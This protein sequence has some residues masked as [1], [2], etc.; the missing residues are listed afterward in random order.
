VWVAGISLAMLSACASH[1]P[2]I[3][4]APRLAGYEHTIEVPDADLLTV[5]PQMQ[6]FLDRYVLPYENLDTR[7]QL[8]TLAVTHSGVIGFTRD[9]D[10][11]LTASEAFRQRT[12][13][14]LS[15]ANM[16]V[17]LARASGLEANYQ[18][19]IVQPQWSS[20][21][22]T[23]LLAKHIN[24]AVSSRHYRYVIDVT[25]ERVPTNST[26][27]LLSDRQAASLYYN[28]LGVEA[29][30]DNHLPSAWAHIN[31]AIETAP[32]LS[33]PWVNMGVV[34]SRNLQMHDAEKSH[35]NALALNSLE[36]TALSNL[37]DVYIG[38]GDEA[39]AAE[40]EARVE[41]Y[42]QGNPY[43]LLMLSNE[44]FEQG[45]FRKS[46]RLLEKAVRK[47]DDDHAL[48]FA[49]ARARFLTGQRDEALTAYEKA[50]ALAPGQVQSDFERALEDWVNEATATV[51]N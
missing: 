20:R 38:M 6:A 10:R 33:S 29:L 9:D 32:G 46:A 8:L 14:C 49:L 45:Q 37:Y 21:E 4:Q 48:H 44:A 30:L 28:N 31:K 42:R 12:G 22:D 25:G 47:K 18:E 36:M 3:D 17:A 51:E 19:V 26:R 24:V 43:Y 15:Y 40:V 11:T 41:K 27:H 50:R 34:M 2:V 5:S 7:L 13:N 1:T 39:R 16:V 35:R 23:I